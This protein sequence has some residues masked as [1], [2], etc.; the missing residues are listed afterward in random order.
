MKRD[1]EDRIIY[2]IPVSVSAAHFFELHR[3]EIGMEVSPEQANKYMVLK[4]L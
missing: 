4:L 3:K 1:F 2:L